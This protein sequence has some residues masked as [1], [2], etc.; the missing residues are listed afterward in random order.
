MAARLG[1]AE[2]TVRRHV[3][4]ALAKLQVTDRDAAVQL[5]RAARRR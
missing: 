1:I 4:T 2:V 3:S 5:L